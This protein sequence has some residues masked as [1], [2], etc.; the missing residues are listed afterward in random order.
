LD[1]DRP[2]I[3]HVASFDAGLRR[4]VLPATAQEHRLRTLLCSPGALTAI[5]PDG[6]QVVGARRSPAFSRFDGNLSGLAVP[7]PVTMPT[8]ATRLERWMDC[9]FAYFVHDLLGV[10]PVENPE[11]ELR[12][13][14]RDR[15]EL[16]HK[17]LELFIVSILAGAVPAPDQPWTFADH[18]RIE[19]IA[20]GQ[21]AGFAARGLAGR[22]IF[23]PREQAMI[24]R[25]LHLIL[26][27]DSAHRACHRTRPLAA[28][29]AFGLRGAALEAVA[30]P[31]PDGRTVRFRGKADRVD[32]ADDGTLHIVD[33]KTGRVGDEDKLSEDNPVLDGKRLQLPIYGLAARLHAADPHAAVYAEYWFVSAKGQYRRH[34]IPVTASVVERVGETLAAIVEG[35]EGGVFPNHPS[36]KSTSFRNEC[37]YCDPDYLG[38]TELRGLWERKRSDPHLAAYA[39]RVEPLDGE[40]EDG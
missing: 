1:R 15:G 40:P 9:P 12:L 22:P 2:W 30:V 11:E 21:F 7:S 23:W 33:Y 8:S 6:A 20:A 5:A 39:D 10:E 34:G 31:L 35:I 38:V 16:V 17:V 14:P 3:D 36:A 37:W 18:E 25:D 32:R 4:L 19:A 24:R 29:L 13:T 26:D 27:L 28:E